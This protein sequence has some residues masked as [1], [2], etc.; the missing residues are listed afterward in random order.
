MPL[1]ASP[2]YQSNVI[3]KSSALPLPISNETPD[4]RVKTIIRAY[5]GGKAAPGSLGAKRSHQQLAIK[6][7][8]FA[9]N[10]VGQS[11]TLVVNLRD[12]PARMINLCT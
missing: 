7:K 3:K 4:F 9:D 8:V 10:E 5:L 6:R 2:F 1:Q 12:A 11:V